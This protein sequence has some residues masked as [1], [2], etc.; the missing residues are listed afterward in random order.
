MKVYEAHRFDEY[1]RDHTEIKLYANVHRAM[2]EMNKIAGCYVE[3]KQMNEHHW[4]GLTSA[5]PRDD[6]YIVYIKNVI[7]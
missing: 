1:W 6:F 3:W 4:A 7:I 2:D 5:D